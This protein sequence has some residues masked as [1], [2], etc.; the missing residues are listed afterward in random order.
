MVSDM[1]EVSVPPAVAQY[2]AK[3]TL[4]TPSNIISF[5]RALMVAPAVMCIVGHLYLLAACIC[6]VAVI[7]DLLDGMLARR[8]DSVSEW[9]KIIDPLADKIFVGFMALTMAAYGLVP[10]WFLAVIV[11]RDLLI[12]LGGT[13]VKRKLGVVLPSNYPGKVAVLAIG[14]NLFLA[15]LEIQGNALLYTRWLAVVLMAISLV[16][17]GTRVKS[18]FAAVPAKS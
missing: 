9:G 17:Y 11:G 14:L 1:P 13:W 10:W 3:D 2:R 6:I 16:M 18:L 15:L 8:L 5:M 4:V 7:S 12:I